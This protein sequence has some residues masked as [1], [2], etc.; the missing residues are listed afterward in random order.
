MVVAVHQELV[1]GRLLNAKLSSNLF[2]TLAGV[3]SAGTK[4]G[5]APASERALKDTMWGV[6]VC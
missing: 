6:S 4:R 5:Q 3:G 2:E 1:I